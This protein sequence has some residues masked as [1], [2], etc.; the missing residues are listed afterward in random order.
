MFNHSMSNTFY[1]FR[2]SIFEFEHSLNNIKTIVW[3]SEQKIYYFIFE[4]WN[5]KN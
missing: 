4:E 1:D 5:K 2:L 3:K